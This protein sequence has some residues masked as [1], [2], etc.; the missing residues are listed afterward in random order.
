LKGSYTP[1]TEFSVT[2]RD[3]P[4]NTLRTSSWNPIEIEGN[5]RRPCPEISHPV[6]PP[7]QASLT[8]TGSKQATKNGSNSNPVGASL[9][10][11]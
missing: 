7:S 3:Y 6:R 11:N 9:L 2:T 8:P 5:F 10:A 4:W 1:I